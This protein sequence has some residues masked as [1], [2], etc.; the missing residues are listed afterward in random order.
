MKL[1]TYYRSQA[2]FRVRIALN[3]KG[4]PH[5]DT[6]LHLER[7]DQ[8]EFVAVEAQRRSGCRRPRVA[9]QCQVRCDA[10]L[11]G[12][13]IEDE[14]DRIDEKVGRPVIGEP[15]WLRGRIGRGVG[16]GKTP[17]GA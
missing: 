9:V 3:L 8:F 4:L 13:E 5:E 15:G 11:G 12:T 16:H 14:V 10:G 6:F 1:Y 2:S 7:G 17:F